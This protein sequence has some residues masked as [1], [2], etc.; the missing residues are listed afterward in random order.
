MSVPRP[1][2]DEP[3]R[4]ALDEIGH[5]LS[6]ASSVRNRAGDLLD[7]RLEFVNSEAAAWTGLPREAVIGRHVGD[8]LPALRTS[9]LFDE[10]STV[11]ETGTPFR[12]AGVRFD[13]AVIDGRHVGGRFDMGAMRLGDGYLSVWQDIGDGESESEALDLTLRRVHGL[14]RLIRLESHGLRLLRPTLAT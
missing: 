8:L 3:V 14:I 2:L 13:D 10:L 1:V 7:F 12:R 9:G 4:A 11:V 6:I 5:P